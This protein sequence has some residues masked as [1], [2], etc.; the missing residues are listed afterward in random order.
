MASQAQVEANRA[1][2][3]KSTGPKTDQGKAVVSQNAVKHGLLAEQV[4]IKGEDPGE[5][6]F[7][8][9]AMMKELCPVGE[10]ESM[11][12]ERA[13][14]LA[15]RLRRAERLQSEVFGTLLANAASANHFKKLTRAALPEKMRDGVEVDR[16]QTELGD[17]V[18]RDCANYRVLERMGLYEQRI[19]RSFYRT[20]DELHKHR[21]MRQ[22]EPAHAGKSEIRSTK[23][24]TNPNDRNS[25][26]QNVGRASPHDTSQSGG[27]LK[28]AGLGDGEGGF[29]TRHRQTPFGAATRVIDPDGAAREIQTKRAPRSAG[30]I[31][32]VFTPA[33]PKLADRPE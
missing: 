16:G 8:R 15:W 28:S 13:V 24:E 1:N 7:Y 3:A 9:E 30:V 32:Q 19:E 10:V 18:V 14:G 31:Q 5:F 33:R 2:A 22:A 26:D 11:L 25:N 27:S 17:A 21:L 6:E 29:E 20:M 12:A 4:V 23:F